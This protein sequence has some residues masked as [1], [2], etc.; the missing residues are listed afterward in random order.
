M[1]LVELVVVITLM[2]VF[3]AAAMTRFSRGT[4]GDAGARSESRILANALLHAQQA[5]IRTG[6]PHGIVFAGAK[7]TRWE[8]VERTLGGRSVMVDSHDIANEVDVTV[9]RREIWFDFEGHG[10]EALR[11]NIR[12]PHREFQLEVVPLSRAI[13]TWE[14]R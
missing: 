7:A 5:A 8:T 11:V 14:V 12:G 10:S 2:G 9:S 1:S 6:R 4:L 13:R 3:A